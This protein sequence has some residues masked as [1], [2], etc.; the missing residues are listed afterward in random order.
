VV[1]NDRIQEVTERIVSRS[2]NQRTRYLKAI[3]R[4]ALG[5]TARSS[6]Q[7]SNL[8]HSCAASSALDKERLQG[9][10]VPNLGIV[11]SY[12]D[13]LSAHQPYWS[14]PEAIRKTARSLGAVAQVAGGV[15]AMCDGV[16][17]GEMGMSFSLFSRDVIAMSTGIALSHRTFDAV[18]HLGICDKIVPGLV[19]GTLSFGHIPAIFVPSGP[20]PTGMS[21]KKKSEIRQQYLEGKINEADLLAMESAV[22]H[23]PGTCTFYGTA[24][25]NQILMEVMGLHLPGA[26]FINPG[27]PSREDMTAM[28]VERV[29]G[30]TEQGGSYTPVG[31]M[32]DERAFVNGIVALNATGG[33]PNHTIHLIA[34]ARAAGITL[35]WEDFADISE[36]VP[37]LANIYPN[38]SA[39]VNDFHKAGGVQF[40]I[41]EL[42][43]AGFLHRDVRTVNGTGLDGYSLN[44]KAQGGKREDSVEPDQEK[45][46]FR[47]GK[48]AMDFSFSASEGSVLDEAVSVDDTVLRPVTNPFYVTGGLK[49]LK[50]NLGRAITRISSV[51]EEHYFIK[52]PAVIF[53]SPGQVHDAFRKGQLEKDFVAVLRYQGPR[54]NGMPELHKLTLILKLLQGRGWSVALLTDGRLSGASNDVLSVI[55]VTPEAA[56]GGAI[57]RVCEGDIIAID[58]L[59]GSIDVLLDDNV[60]SSRHIVERSVFS[61]LSAFDNEA[62]LFETFRRVVGPADEGAISLF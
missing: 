3:K 15:P 25:S 31:E 19:M 58:A 16:T 55:H 30:L 5:S 22:Y 35:R 56:A 11:T 39:D 57:A 28:A 45:G 13:I 32:L 52:A 29:L 7:C 36:V 46:G 2:S 12:N 9:K 17:Q 59:Q 20:M 42:L 18:L 62:M 43:N 1:F 60:L 24:N 37:L 14:Y 44:S 54:A 34:M 27:N 61:N 4:E 40:L 21:N 50:G 48:L 41:T 38:G 26:T 53:D 23:A 8:A 33:S 47:K 49:L 6:L 51:R 10:R